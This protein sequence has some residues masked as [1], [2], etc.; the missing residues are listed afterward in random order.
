MGVVATV[1]LLEN[2]F[3]EWISFS[4]FMSASETNLLRMKW[5]TN[6]SN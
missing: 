4:R 6:N 3:D 2:N 1:K 5:H